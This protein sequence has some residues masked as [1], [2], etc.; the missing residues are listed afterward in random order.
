V[1]VRHTLLVLDQSLADLGSGFVQAWLG[2]NSRWHR[3]T[4]VELKH[5]AHAERWLLCIASSQLSTVTHITSEIN[6]T[7][8]KNTETSGRTIQNHWRSQTEG[9]KRDYFKTYAE[10]EVRNRRNETHM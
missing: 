4:V 2:Q 10:T 3:F 7:M 5:K 6:V 1:K 8:R 9:N